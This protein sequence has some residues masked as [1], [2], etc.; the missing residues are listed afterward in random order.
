MPAAN[1]APRPAVFF[2]RDGTVNADKGYTH[3]PD[4]LIFLPGA[5]AAVKRVNDLGWY[6]FLVTNQSGVARGYF[7]ETD[8]KAFHIHMQDQLRTAG[9]RF[10]D[11]R[12]C[13]HHPEGKV[14]AY[15]R[16]CDCRKP[17]AGMILDLMRNWPVIR[18][19]SLV[20]GNSDSD[21]QA[22]RGAGLR[23]I[24]Y[25]GGNLDELLAAHLPPKKHNTAPRSSE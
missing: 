6:A 17:K 8:V 19:G 21:M 3:R 14:E 15:A 12:Y 4:D 20:V 2:D 13:P 5:V 22:A 23:A 24:R 1:S 16:A 7:T 25:D 18:E 10:D 11:I 9:A